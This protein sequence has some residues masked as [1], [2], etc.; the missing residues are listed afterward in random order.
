MTPKFVPK[1]PTLAP[2]S[3]CQCLAPTNLDV[4]ALK[5]V[6][7]APSTHVLGNSPGQFLLA[8]SKSNFCSKSRQ[9]RASGD[10]F[11]RNS[12]EDNSR[13]LAKSVAVA[14]DGG[15]SAAGCH[16]TNDLATDT[17]NQVTHSNNV[18]TRAKI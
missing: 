18:A 7:Q 11:L 14:C 8:F 15:K 9:A 2:F 1:G 10:M 17:N 4:Q 16:H 5:W 6:H 12:G 13:D 3:Q